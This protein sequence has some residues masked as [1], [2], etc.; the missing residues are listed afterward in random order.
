LTGSLSLMIANTSS[1]VGFVALAFFDT[2]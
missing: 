1:F 2:M